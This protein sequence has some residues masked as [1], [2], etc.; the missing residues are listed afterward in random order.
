MTGLAAVGTR[1][2]DSPARAEL[3]GYAANNVAYCAGLR[4]RQ[5]FVHILPVSATVPYAPTKLR[6]Q[7]KTEHCVTIGLLPFVS[8]L[9]CWT[10]NHAGI[11]TYACI[12]QVEHASSPPSPT[13]E[14]MPGTTSSYHDVIIWGPPFCSMHVEDCVISKFC[15]AI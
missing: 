9:S 7:Y 8:R 2:Y 6:I 13:M 12:W 10:W 11:Y 5:R 14:S 4:H 15:H 3:Y 1:L